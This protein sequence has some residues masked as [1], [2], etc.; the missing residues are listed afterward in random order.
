MCDKTCVSWESRETGDTH[1]SVHATFVLTQIYPRWN[2]LWTIWKS[3]KTLDVYP[4]LP[5]P[6]PLMATWALH[7]YGTRY[8]KICSKHLKRLIKSLHVTFMGRGEGS[9]C[10]LDTHIPVAM[11]KSTTASTPFR[12]ISGRVTDFSSIYNI[13]R[14]MQI[15]EEVCKCEMT[16]RGRT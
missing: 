5:F 14:S 3:H 15:S 4:I 12:R 8:Q 1:T 10:I 7:F 11:L 6:A 9:V 2:T 13:R 16:G